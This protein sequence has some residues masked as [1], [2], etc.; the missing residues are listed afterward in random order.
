[1]L[2]RPIGAPPKYRKISRDPELDYL[3]SVRASR[4]LGDEY[5]QAT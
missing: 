2:D 4:R 3:R 5:D 1:M